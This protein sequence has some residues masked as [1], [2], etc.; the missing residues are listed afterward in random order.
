[1]PKAKAAPPKIET[2]TQTLRRKAVKLKVPDAQLG[3]L[4]PKL[5]TAPCVPA[6]RQVVDDWRT[7]RYPKITDTTRTLLNYWFRSE[8]RL[9]NGQKFVYHDSQRHAIETLIYLYEVAGVRRHRTLLET[10]ASKTPGVHVLEQDDFA[11]YC[12][13]MAT[14]S[15]K[16]KVMSLVIA[17]QFLNA[18]AEARPEYA[19]TFLLIAPNIIVLERLATDFEGGRIFRADPV[20]PPELAVYWDFDCYVRDEPERAHA[21]G[22]LYL[23]NVQQLYERRDDGDGNE[24]EE[25]RGVLGEKPTGALLSSEPFGARLAKRKLPLAVLN[26]EAHHTH[27]EGSEW[28]AVIRRV[29]ESLSGG[30]VAQFDFSATPRYPKGGLFTWT[31]YDYPLK[32]AIIDNIVKRPMKG[33]AKGI[34]E[35]RSDL[36]SVRYRA[37]IT[38]GVLRWREY[39]EQ[40]AP[41][42]KKP[43][44]FLMLTSTQE[45]D[46]VGD[47]LRSKYPAEFGDDEFGNQ[48]LVIIHTDRSGEVSKKSLELARKASREVDRTESPVNAIVSVL[49]LREGWDVQNVTVVVGLRPFTS[50]ANILPEQTI[51]RGLRRMFRGV[52]ADYVERLDVIGNKAFIEFVEQLEK[53]EGMELDT[54]VVAKDKL[55]IVTVFPDPDKLAMDIALPTLSPILARKKSLAEE[56]AAIDVSKLRVPV[57]PIKPGDEAA[58]RFHYEGY[59][60]VTLQKIIERDYEIPEPQTAQEVISYYARRIAQD[61]KLPSQFAAIVPKIREFLERKAFGKP[62]DIESKVMIKAIANNVAQYVTVKTFVQALRVRIVEELA[63][64]LVHAGRK[65]SETPGFP[66]SRPTTS[67]TKTVFNV[68]AVENEFERR[69]AKFLEAAEDVARFAKLPEQFGFAIEYM[70]SMSNLRYYEPDFIVVLSDG[71]HSLVETKGR[72]DPDVKF[73]DRAAAIWC[74]NATMLAGPIWRYVQVPQKEFEKLDPDGFSDLAALTVEF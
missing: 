36:A 22:A 31:V 2:V 14:G 37:Y 21:E 63:P 17:W 25:M 45:A 26:D 32:Q 15:G 51:G 47:Y 28:T 41:L 70:D 66:F 59:D 69:F 72:E 30:M 55:Q 6:V 48:R 39:L 58:Q 67:A 4:Q 71:T 11:R 60:M 8:H 20:I 7:A 24:P 3:L 50:K 9:P 34:Q 43:V 56:I 61:L 23:T 53:D 52:S 29:H 42:G 12:V 62:V 40:L 65:L 10:F 46:D 33:I 44:L 64:Q 35:Q 74:E 57:L 13:K 38:A 18:V 5:P 1:M 73:K 27:D 49:M 54:F 19:K 68:V 16:T